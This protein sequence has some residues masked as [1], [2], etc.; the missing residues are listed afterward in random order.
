MRYRIVPLL[1]LA[2][3]L[4]GLAGCATDAQNRGPWHQYLHE[5]GYE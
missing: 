1:A 4:L 5:H 3:L 2:G